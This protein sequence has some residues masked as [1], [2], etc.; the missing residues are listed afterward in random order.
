MSGPWLS[1][2]SNSQISKGTSIYGKTSFSPTQL[3]IDNPQWYRMGE[4]KIGAKWSS[5]FAR[6]VNDFRLEYIGRKDIWSRIVANLDHAWTECDYLNPRPTY[7]QK[8]GRRMGFRRKNADEAP[9]N[10]RNWII[11]EYYH[12]IAEYRFELTQIMMISIP[13]K[14]Y[15]VAIR[16]I[17]KYF[18]SGQ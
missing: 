8:D 4:V 13:N 14:C 10:C 7:H 3:P 12:K 15:V 2:K 5:C 18:S 9:T 17:S 16:I 1:M 11:S 6:R